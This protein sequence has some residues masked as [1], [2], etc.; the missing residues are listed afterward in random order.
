MPRYVTIHGHFY[1][2]PRE[3]PWL[4]AVELQDSAYPYHDWNERIH[5]ECY[6][7]NA[8][9]RIL[10]ENN[11][12]V[13]IVNNYAKIS[14]NFG[15]TLLTWMQEFAPNTYQAVLDADRES[16][17]RFS[18]HGSAIAQAYNHA[19]LPLANRRDK[20]TQVI[21]GVRDFVHRF[22]RSPEGMWLPETAVD[23]ETLE[24]LAEN[25]IRF[26]ILSPHQ[27]RRV[28]RL[29]GADRED[30]PGGRI[31]PTR[32]YL[33]NLPSGLSIALFFYDGPISRAVAFEGLLRKGEH[34]A[35]RLTDAFTAHRD[36]PQLVHIA[37]DGETYGH[38]HRFGDMALAYALDHIEKTD[39][40]RLTNYGEYLEK[41]PP[42]HAVEIEERTSWSCSHGIERWRANCGCRQGGKPGWTQDWRAPLRNAFDFLRDTLAPLYEASASELFRDP[43][44]ARDDYIQVVLDRSR[45]NVAE[46]F[47]E[48]ALRP[49]DEEAEIVALKLLELQRQSLLMY[50]SCGWFF[51][52][53]TNIETVQV[54]QYAGRAL[55]LAG[56]LFGNAELESQFLD[57]LERAT[58]NRGVTGRD[59]YEKQVRPAV[60]DLEKM[61]AHHALSSL[62]EDYPPRARVYC[63]AVERQDRE[64]FEA[65]RAKL[66]LGRARLE[67]EITH[68]AGNWG[69]AGLYAG[70]RQLHGHL[71]PSQSSED[72]LR[73]VSQVA[74]PFAS[75]DLDGV[76]GILERE[77]GPATY[78]ITSL[79]R[80][81]QRKIVNRLL[82]DTVSEVEASY[83]RI[84]ER[85]R[86]LWKFVEDLD[87]PLPRVL[88][89]TAEFVLNTNLRRA[90]ETTEVDPDRVGP[91]VK[92]TI[93]ARIHLDKE[94][95]SYSIRRGLERT[96]TLWARVPEDRS[97]LEKLRATL[98]LVRALPI[99]VDLA[100]VQN[101]YYALY[102]SFYPERAEKARARDAD[103]QAWCEFFVSLGELL[104]FRLNP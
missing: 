39:L 34:L 93:L 9:S 38:H 72:Y 79:F 81:E 2:P 74:A 31:D 92:D 64:S 54:I 19:I 70:E 100:K 85:Y 10:D 101:A 63:Y 60:V 51:D 57:R 75:G 32:A 12:I 86:P 83:R 68:A 82:E 4:E 17:A 49:M 25:G 52:D 103:A 69:Y 37:T 67:S 97:R 8:A 91:I 58:S 96:A 88:A 44:A 29:D 35:G 22:G 89:A 36:W 47:S 102:R 26:T 27:A 59:I 7:P 30:V 62:F 21:W 50:T 53:L 78:S 5:V 45:E 104:S 16:R 77:L 76:K 6:A 28:S 41:H 48:R 42:S 61:A 1:Q 90:F 56:A 46:F 98:L 84:H 14:F 13:D 20:Q 23:L 3:N 24:V 94:T 87:V 99:E 15:P 80:E 73:V 33:Q 66:V 40:A 43:W 55:Q 18:G 95:L 71:K 11:R 65:G